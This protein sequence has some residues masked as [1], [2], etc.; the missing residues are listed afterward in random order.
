MI[1]TNSHSL[2]FLSLSFFFHS[3]V[4]PIHVTSHRITSIAHAP[5]Q[6]S[7]VRTHSCSTRSTGKGRGAYQNKNRT[8]YDGVGPS[9]R[10]EKERK[11]G[12]KGIK[13]PHLESAS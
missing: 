5:F 13:T 6:D 11:G 10:K 7:S 1:A 8:R 9:K 3:I 4:V 2:L 12:G